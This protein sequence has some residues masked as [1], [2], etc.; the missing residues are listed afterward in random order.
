M[1]PTNNS[2]NNTLI[3][4]WIFSLIFLNFFASKLTQLQIECK[5]IEN[6]FKNIVLKVWLYKQHSYISEE[7]LIKLQGCQTW[8]P[9]PVQTLRQ[10]V[11]ADWQNQYELDFSLVFYTYQK[12]SFFWVFFIHIKK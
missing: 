9:N 1:D 12:Q 11:N 3:I 2:Y 4:F 5:R 6:I 7:W 8:D 10:A